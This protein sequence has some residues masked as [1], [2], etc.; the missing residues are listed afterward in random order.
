MPKVVLDTNIF[1]SALFWRGKP[2]GVM[3]KCLQGEIEL[4][5][6][7]EILNQG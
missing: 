3:R 7:E 1:V 6:P 4:L 5:T 2:Y